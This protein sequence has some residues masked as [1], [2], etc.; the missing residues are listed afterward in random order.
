MLP[1]TSR[2]RFFATIRHERPQRVPMDLWARPEIRR[3]LESHFGTAQVE[4]ALGVDFVEVA[5]GDRFDDFDARAASPRG[6]DWPGAVGRY[7]WHDERTYE[8]GW[9]IVHRVGED[10]K[11]VQWLSGPLVERTDLSRIAFAPTD[12]LEDP[13]R[14]AAQVADHKA[15]DRV[16]TGEVV[17][18]F[19]RAW[20]L[21]GLENL[22][23][24]MV[25]DTPFVEALY[26]RIY[27]FETER[28]VRLARAGVDLIKVI[29][30]IAM[31]DRLLFNPKLFDQLDKPR[32]ANMIR[33][34]REVRPETVFFYHSDGKLDAAI[35]GLIAAGFDIINPIQPECMDPYA[36]KQRWGDRV[37]L[38]GTISVRTTLPKGSPEEIRRVVR[39]RIRRCGH[40]GGFVLAPA[41]VIMYDTPLENVLALYEAGRDFTWDD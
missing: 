9:G 27:A 19:K 4:D 25:V 23:C 39:E 33:K 10:G 37:T 38:W 17:M 34:V 40:D 21:R 41:N 31:E 1:E 30:D 20:Q 32:L 12:H 8:D 28:A 3:M 29:G 14:I 2:Q 24:D 36:T 13:D 16:V 26:D 5:I 35:D 18:P 7:I 22:L 6:G 11:I 15:A